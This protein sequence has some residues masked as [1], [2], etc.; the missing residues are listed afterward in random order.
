[1]HPHIRGAI[2][3]VFFKR[4]CSMVHPHIRG[5]NAETG[6]GGVGAGRFILT[7]VGLMVSAWAWA[8]CWRGS[9]PHTWG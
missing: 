8:L 7:Y 9:S 4:L 5:V 1:M 3:P 6:Q 2:E